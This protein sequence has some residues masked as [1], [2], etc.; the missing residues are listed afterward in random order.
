MRMSA[1][2]G[3]TLRRAPS[4]TEAAGHALLLRAG[5]VRQLASGIFSYLPL[6]KRTDAY[7]PLPGQPR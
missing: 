2:F 1:M 5:F 3:L 4:N 7:P 6:A